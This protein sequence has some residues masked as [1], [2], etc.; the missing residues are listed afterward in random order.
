MPY[1]RE[2]TFSDPT[3]RIAVDWIIHSEKRKIA[4]KPIPTVV[5]ESKIY[6]KN[7]SPKVGE[8]PTIRQRVSEIENILYE[9]NQKRKKRLSPE[10]QMERKKLLKELK[11]IKQRLI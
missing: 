9:Y 8:I 1:V 7:N 11:S 10:E 6:P 3:A 4:R 5:F 2:R